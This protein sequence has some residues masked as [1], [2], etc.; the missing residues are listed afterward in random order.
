MAVVVVWEQGGLAYG[1]KRLEKLHQV[2]GWSKPGL[3]NIIKP[4]FEIP[5][6]FSVIP[7]SQKGSYKMQLSHSVIY[8]M[9]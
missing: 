7:N 1:E 6:H 5:V 8:Q 9:K 2:P 4:F 3:K